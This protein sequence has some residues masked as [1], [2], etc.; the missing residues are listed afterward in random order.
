MKRV[1]FRL[2]VSWHEIHKALKVA[3]PLNIVD[4]VLTFEMQYG[5]VTRQATGEEQPMQQWVDMSNSDGSY[6]ASLLN[7]SKYACD[8]RGNTIRLTILRSPT[9][10]AYNTDEGIH[11]VKYSL[12]PHSRAWKTS[13]VA[14][15]GYEFNN[16]LIPI[17]G[18]FTRAMG[19]NTRKLP[20][21]YSFLHTEP[22][23]LIVTTFKKAEEG[24]SF[25][26]R[27][28]EVAG[29]ETQANISFNLGKII[30]EA[31][32]TDLLEDEEMD[33]EVNIEKNLLEFKVSPYEIATIKLDMVL[34]P[35]QD[36]YG[37]CKNI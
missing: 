26:L 21:S 37:G 19:S 16:P 13:G 6:G 4:P 2:V 27:L 36:S 10:P 35:Y 30:R 32:K 31:H 22:E 33:D 20:K 24:E 25:V 15:K 12:F 1:D 9:E 28:Y 29:K 14:R 18:A 34:H 11:E 7:D 23:N 8:V 3:F 17:V 5:S